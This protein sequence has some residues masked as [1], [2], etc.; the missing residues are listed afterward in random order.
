VYKEKNNKKKLDILMAKI[1]PAPKLDT[2]IIRKQSNNNISQR[3]E[4]GWKKEEPT[5]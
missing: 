4:E 1:K 5:K 3:G 2:L